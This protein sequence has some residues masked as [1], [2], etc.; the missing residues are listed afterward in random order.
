MKGF[1]EGDIQF[2]SGQLLYTRIVDK[3]CEYV[4]ENEIAIGEKIPSERVLSN[5][6]GVSRN[7]VREAIRELESKGIVQVQA[8]RGLF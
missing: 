2:G 7:S 6:L 5:M 8:G 4:K 1:K 3:I